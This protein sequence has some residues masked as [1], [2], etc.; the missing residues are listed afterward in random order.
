MQFLENKAFFL[1][2]LRKLNKNMQEP[3]NERINVIALVKFK[4]LYRSNFI[5]CLKR[6]NVL[7]NSNLIDSSPMNKTTFFKNLVFQSQVPWT[8]CMLQLGLVTDT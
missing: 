7:L 6:D 3:D 5:I 8:S 2:Q 4:F 1:Y